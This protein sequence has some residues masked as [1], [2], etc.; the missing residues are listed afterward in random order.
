MTGLLLAL[1]AAVGVHLMIAPRGTHG[2]ASIPNQARTSGRPSLAARADTWLTQAGLDAVRPR[3]FVLA[4]GLFAIGA[5]VGASVVFGGLLPG[6][7]ASVLAGA[8]P[9]V[10]AH[11]RRRTRQQIAHEAWPRLIEEMRILT[12]S[13]GRSIPQA[14]FEV[15]STA[16]AELQP[17]FDAAHR[18]WLMSTD[19]DQ[20]TRMMKEQL[21]DPTADVVCETLLLAY[22]LGGTALDRRLADL[23]ADRRADVQYRKDA[24]ARQAGVR[25]ARRFVVIVPIGMAAAGMSVGD[26]KHAYATPTGQVAVVAALALMAICWWWAGR[27]LRLPTQRRVFAP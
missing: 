7:V 12:N 17:A 21:G 8:I 22:E 11:Q 26:G 16:P 9:V 19:F 6:L 15:R 1:S 10:S 3:D 14:L 13:V 2:S 23:A 18:E 27:L 4:A 24:R 25:F 20:T 5:G